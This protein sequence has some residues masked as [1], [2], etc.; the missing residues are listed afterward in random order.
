MSFVNAHQ[1][2]MKLS[3]RK[4]RCLH[5]SNGLQCNEI[6]SA[7]SIQ[8]RGQLGLIAESDHVYRLSADLSILKKNGGRPLP[9]KTGVNRASTFRGMCKHHDN[10][11]F[12]L[13]D[14]RPLAVD[15]HQVALY[16]YRSICREYFFKENASPNLTSLLEQPGLTSYQSQ[17]LTDAAYGQ[18][19]GFE[20]L[21]R[22]KLIYD[23]CLSGDDFTGLKFIIFEST[24]RCSLQVS[25]LI[26]PV[27]DFQ[28][29]QLQDLG[30]ETKDLDLLVFFT[31]PTEHGWAFVLAWHE[32]SDLSCQR[33]KYSLAESVRD[34]GKIE[35]ILLRFSLAC[36]ENHAIRIS[37]WDSLPTVAR[38]QA[39]DLMAYMADPTLEIRS[40]YLAAGCEGL[41]DWSFASVQDLS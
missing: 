14:D 30:P 28:A 19:L 32:S 16:A 25:G 38:N 9:K 2:S 8:K 11:L 23:R 22:H 6:I 21:K 3:N 31:A 15:H 39:L 13:I 26:F 10:K 41:A 1:A 24:S 27:F 33:F 5:F 36:C 20:R 40:D 29:R 37:W 35:D 7:H 17:L 18:Y 12:S 34:G 4:G